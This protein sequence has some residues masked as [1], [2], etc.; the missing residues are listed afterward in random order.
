MVQAAAAVL[1][2][3]V[4][5]MSGCWMTGTEERQGRQDENKKK[6]WSGPAGDQPELRF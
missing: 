6:N 1:C 5:R 4:S 3:D 2:T